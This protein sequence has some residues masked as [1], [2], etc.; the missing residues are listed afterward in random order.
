MKPRSIAILGASEDF[1][2]LNGIPLKA[3]LDKGYAGPIYPVNPKY[4]EIAGLKCYPTVEAIPG[5][6]DLAVITVSH[7]RVIES[8]RALGRKGVG[9]AVVFASGFAEV[10]GEGIALQRELSEVARETGVR[11]LGP[12]CLGMVNAFEKVMASFAKFALE[13]TPGGPIGMV[14]QSGALGS[15]TIGVGKKRGLHVGYLVTI[16]NEADIGFVEAMK[17]VMADSRIRVCAGF[18]EGV[19]DGAGFVE[20][21]EQAQQEGKPLVLTKLGRT[22]AGARAIASHT[23]SLAGSDAIFDGVSRQYGVIRARSDE[24]LLDFANA[25]SNCPLPAGNRVGILT[26]SGGAGAL[27]VDR[28]AE[29]GLQ[30]SSLTGETTAALKAIL[31]EFGSFANPVDV[32]A[33]GMF[34]PGLICD[35]FELVLNDPN[36][37]I[38]IAWMGSTRDVDFMVKAFADL[39]ARVQK[40]F[41]LAWVGA[42]D[43]AVE[44]LAAENVAVLR[45]P[46]PAVDAVAALVRYAEMR[47]HWQADQAARE[48]TRTEVARLSLPLPATTG[49]VGTQASATLLE[50]A[51][52]SVA[53]LALSTTA[54]EAAV[55]AEKLGYPVVL[56]IESPQ[57]LHKTEAK[58]VELN[59]RDADAVR[60]AFGRIMD[61]VREYDQK[62][63][64][65]GVIVQK[66]I[67]QPDAVELVVGLNQ[68]PVF[69]PVVMVGLGGV[70]IEVLRDVAFRRAPVSEAEAGRM[71]DELRGA[72]VLA[73][74]R[75]KKPVDR[76]ALCGFIAAVSRFGAAAGARL[77]ELDLNPVLASPAGCV[78]VDNLLVLR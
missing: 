6:V 65:D 41:V 44:R 25:F 30:I 28:A 21:T 52:V 7:T 57:I 58:G 46:E 74:V 54:D 24:Q 12:N 17:E 35:A 68:D 39:R 51:G 13:P 11:V 29:T 1:R 15:S 45:G 34:S 2:K 76:Q 72:A 16:G 32:T 67:S 59:L 23:G 63:Q 22:D 33:V 56:K 71:L 77:G 5:E 36:I 69:G 8:I 40:P 62:A 75:G 50:S 43:H 19:R 3:L 26:R 70:L 61:N 38:G 10:G 53:P 9:A 14:T 78:A 27:M 66:M 42:E 47:R 18:V 37:D 4:K 20:L 48:V 64:V 49:V 31:P 60:A 55:A 73:G